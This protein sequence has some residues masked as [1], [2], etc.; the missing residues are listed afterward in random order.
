MTHML[1]AAEDVDHIVAALIVW[2]APAV[3]VEL[4]TN[5]TVVV[6]ME[7]VE[8]IPRQFS[9]LPNQ[10]LCHRHQSKF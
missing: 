5:Q 2:V 1:V 4:L 6:P 9:R 10:R 8:H 7:L 3:L